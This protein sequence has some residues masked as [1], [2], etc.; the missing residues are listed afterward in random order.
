MPIH[1]KTVR[2]F[3]EPGV[4]HYLTFSCL[5]RQQLLSKDRT[6]LWLIDSLTK[7]NAKHGMHL[8]AWVIMPEHVHLLVWPTMPYSIA[9]YLRS[10][11][12]PMAKKAI[13]HL[14][15]EA[16]TFLSRLQSADGAF[17]FWQIGPGYDENVSEPRRVHEIIEYIHNNPVKRG[18]C[19]APEDWRWSS[20]RAWRGDLD[21]PIQVQRTHVP[22]WTPWTP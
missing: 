4:A 11:K 5:R 3:D 20:A 14:R 2:H 10:F 12:T 7:A 15:T 18:L 8:W 19:L 1:R 21:V 22:I 6:R 17:H 9:A 16:P 13:T